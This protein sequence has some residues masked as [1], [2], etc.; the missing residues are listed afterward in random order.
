MNPPSYISPVS[1]SS[2]NPAKRLLNTID[3]TAMRGSI[4]E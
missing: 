4:N 3:M 2:N 1:L